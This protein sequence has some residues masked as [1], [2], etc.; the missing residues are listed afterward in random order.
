MGINEA[1]KILEDIKL[2]VHE[3]TGKYFL[4]DGKF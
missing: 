1:S 4:T 2:T 3:T